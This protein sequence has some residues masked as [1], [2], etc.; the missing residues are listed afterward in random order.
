LLLT[1]IVMLGLR[2]SELAEQIKKQ[3]QVIF[4]SG[5]AE[6]LLELA[7]PPGAKSRQKPFRFSYLLEQLTLVPRSDSKLKSPSNGM[8]DFLLRLL[9]LGLLLQ[10]CTLGHAAQA[11]TGL[12]LPPDTPAILDYIYS[13]RIDQAISEARQ[14]QDNEP[15][16]PL[17][18]ILEA[19]A[20]WWKIWWGSAEYK[21]GMT[22]ARHREK[23]PAD[24]PYLDLAT[25][26]YSL[27]TQN[28]AAHDSGEMRLY[29]GMA[30][31]M[32]ARLYG[33]RGEAR[34]TAKFGV[35]ARENM[36]R[37][38]AVDPSMADAY[39]GLGLYSYY[40]DTLSAAAKVL[41]FFM[42]IPGGSK[43]EGI[44]Q[45][46][47]AIAEG[48]LT[49][50]AAR[51]YLAI[52]LHNFD[53]RY[54]EALRVITPLRDKYPQN[55]LFHLVQGDLLA[56]IGKKQQ[57]LEEY[58]LAANCKVP[59]QEC[60]KRIDRLVRESQAALRGVRTTAGG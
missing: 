42:G 59:D 60:Q 49:P 34:N 15:N 9:G 19:E 31:A 10:V 44:R 26:A 7:I 58:Q 40:V 20:L 35:R 14:I 28:L 12:K 30:D 2:G 27:A 8:R 41:R 53:Q 50:A 16:N 18:Y 56:K 32:A 33:L 52:N 55:P 47:R 23:T 13:G 21:Y 45:L 6:G 5:Y 57:A 3:I 36:R 37:A 51:F 24:Q 48:Q 39:F 1:D 43:E 38:L 4:L 46:H 25:K 22:M 11:G 17:G 29:A 54:E